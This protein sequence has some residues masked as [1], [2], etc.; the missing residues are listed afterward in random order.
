MPPP[1]ETTLGTMGGDPT[2]AFERFSAF[3]PFAEDGDREEVDEEEEMIEG[4]RRLEARVARLEAARDATAGGRAR[5]EEERARLR[6]ATEGVFRSLEDVYVD[7]VATDS[8][9]SMR[10]GISRPEG[11]MFFAAAHGLPSAIR[12]L[13]RAGEVG[14]NQPVGMAG[15]TALVVAT[16]RGHERCVEVLIE[17]GANVHPFRVHPNFRAWGGHRLAGGGTFVPLAVTAPF[18]KVGTA[19]LL[20]ARGADVNAVHDCMPFLVRGPVLPRACAY[21]A[22]ELVRLLLQQE[23]I[24]THAVG[25]LEGDDRRYTALELAEWNPL[26]NP[27]EDMDEIRRMLEA[28]T[29]TAESAASGQAPDTLSE[30][31]VRGP[32]PA[33]DSAAGIAEDEFADEFADGDEEEDMLERLSEMEAHVRRLEAD[34]APADAAL[35]RLR[36]HTERLLALLE[37]VHDDYV[38]TDVSV[39]RYPITH[40]LGQLYYAAVRGLRQLIRDLVSGGHVG[41]NAVVGR[42]GGSAICA[43]ALAGQSGSVRTLIGLGAD[44]HARR[45]CGETAVHS[46]LHLSACAG[47]A[48]LGC[49]GALLAAG[50]DVNERHAVSAPDSYYVGTSLG[51][52]CTMGAVETVRLLLAQDGVDIHAACYCH[53]LNAPAM[54]AL[55]LTLLN[56]LKNP[57]ED[58]DAMHAMLMRH[59]HVECIALARDHLASSSA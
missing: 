41:V 17:L 35:R 25:W 30:D 16:R 22:V 54:T 14:I 52:A 19:R 57:R 12:E 6:A 27:A 32:R 8:G 58:V 4:L 10:S 34:G 28:H 33:G 5:L 23:R 29:D 20:L 45:R 1:C 37:T 9:E 36:W 46:A 15:G 38:V 55:E 39:S 3:A 56:P 40:P 44:V 11:R 2:D 21:G 49:A 50:T 7:S 31:L 24:D 13:I 42:Q 51:A 47:D 43:A 59:L 26:S 18:N 53:K 48:G